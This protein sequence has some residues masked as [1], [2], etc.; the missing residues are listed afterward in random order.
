L[1]A[2]LR[3]HQGII[4]IG[5]SVEGVVNHCLAERF[6]IIRCNRS[7]FTFWLSTAMTNITKRFPS[8]V[9]VKSPS[10]SAMK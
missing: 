9:L 5:A 10:I 4:S 8:S 3:N 7:R 6:F 2:V 1:Y